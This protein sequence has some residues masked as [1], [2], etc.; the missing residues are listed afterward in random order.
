MKKSYTSPKADVLLISMEE[1]ACLVAVST[2]ETE[3]FTP[4][5]GLW[6]GPTL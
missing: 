5:P 4:I 6:D 3:G 2:A 1:S